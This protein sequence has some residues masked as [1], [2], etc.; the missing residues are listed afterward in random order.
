ML[1]RLVLKTPTCLIVE[2]PLTLTIRITRY[3]LLKKFKKTRST[4]AL[5]C[6][7]LK[8]KKYYTLDHAQPR[9]SARLTLLS[10]SRSRS[11]TR[12]HS[13][14]S[15]T[16]NVCTLGVA[17]S[18]KSLATSETTSESTPDRD[19]SSASSVARPSHSQVT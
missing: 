19:P 18:L 5:K 13:A 10:T 16:S 14:S 3:R 4:L 9:P 17:Q 15:Y 8:G 7:R 6:H 1:D 2:N 12:R 11:K